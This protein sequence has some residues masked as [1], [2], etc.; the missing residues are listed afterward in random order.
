MRSKFLSALK[1]TAL[2][3]TLL[4]LVG[5]IY[6]IQSEVGIVPT[7]EKYILSTGN[8][9]RTTTSV[10]EDLNFI[11][12]VVNE[13]YQVDETTSIGEKLKHLEQNFS[14]SLKTKLGPKVDS[15]TNYFLDKNGNQSVTIKQVVF[16]EILKTYQ[17]D[18]QVAQ[19]I[20]GS[21]DYTFDIELTLQISSRPTRSVI[22]WEESIRT[23]PFKK[24]KELS[25]SL[26]SNVPVKLILPC[27]IA[28][29]NLLQGSN[30]IE[31]KVSSDSQSAVFSSQ[32]PLLEV[33]IFRINCEKVRFDITFKS[34][35]A[36][37][38]VFANLDLSI[39]SVI[40][41][42]LSPQEKINL[43]IRQQLN[44]W[45]YKKEN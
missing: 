38:L 25:F 5:A 27:R 23:I 17:V 18:L 28:N 21:K 32:E 1:N 44:S 7:F 14:D 37:S 30:N 10:S 36:E 8:K 22:S 39:A 19:K 45:G 4:A 6:I 31:Y 40:S 15:S 11:L 20:V 26:A 29:I 2:A 34:N 3:V 12:N 9:S 13:Y 41:K 43:S 24:T 33:S 42:P 35:E 16:N